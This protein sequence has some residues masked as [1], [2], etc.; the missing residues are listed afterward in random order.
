MKN[1][2][3][4]FTLCLLA[5]GIIACEKDDLRPDRTS[6]TD[7][8][9]VTTMNTELISKQDELLQALSQWVATPEARQWFMQKGG[10]N[11]RNLAT[12]MDEILLLEVACG[13][14]GDSFVDIYN[15]VAGESHNTGSFSTFVQA[16]NP[17]LALKFDAYFGDFL[18][19]MDR[20]V[21]LVSDAQRSVSYLDGEPYNVGG[22]L[23]EAGGTFIIDFRL[24]EASN[25]VLYNPATNSFNRDLPY[26]FCSDDLFAERLHEL[27][28]PIC[29]GEI[30]M[31]IAGHIQTIFYEVCAG[32]VS[33]TTGGGGPEICDNGID[34]DGDGLVD[35]ADPDCCGT[36]DCG[37]CLEVNCDNGIDDDG[38]GLIDED[39][40]DCFSD[41][42]CMRDH[43][44]E[45]NFFTEM[46]LVR[47]EVLAEM[48]ANLC[49]GTIVLGNPY[50]GN[51]RI[52][53]NDR[54]FYADPFEEGDE[55]EEW[56]NFLL[57]I[58]LGTP[59]G[60][61][62]IF[63]ELVYVFHIFELVNAPEFSVEYIDEPGPAPIIA[64]LTVEEQ[65]FSET[66]PVSLEMA[67]IFSFSDV[68][69]VNNWDPSIFGDKLAVSIHEFDP[70][71]FRTVTG[72]VETT[73]ENRTY[74]SGFTIRLGAGFRTGQGGSVSGGF[75]YNRQNSYASSETNQISSSYT[76]N[77]SDDFYMGRVIY[78]Y[79]WQD[80]GTTSQ[81]NEIT[82]GNLVHLRLLSQICN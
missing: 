52:A 24:T 9:E 23:E 66:Y 32:G 26:P 48:G 20:F 60:S 51:S 40:P 44:M 61:D 69:G 16:E 80:Q 17:L 11:A 50:S 27:P 75:L 6:S 79:C 33:I 42:P 3:Y 43:H 4:L 1:L 37:I 56:Y 49:N 15:Q 81:I 31:S 28:E 46:E 39:D 47:P 45:D 34:D 58:H 54:P 73:T 10:S 30:P 36:E 82:F 2:A 53:L 35:C 67:P 77:Y 65:G 78:D 55:L 25:R 22:R 21:P 41:S 76:T 13:S 19:Q 29:S 8:P 70:C 18:D 14:E 57:K 12:A 38:D 5:V 59:V 7:L 62:G 63:Q 74:S 72:E 71:Q 68:C 64:V